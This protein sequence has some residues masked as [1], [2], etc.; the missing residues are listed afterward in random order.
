MVGDDPDRTGDRALGLF[1]IGGVRIAIDVGVL[2]EVVHVEDLKRGID[3]ADT[4]LGM[5]VIRGVLVPVIDPLRQYAPPDR[6]PAIVVVLS[7]GDM[8]TGIGVDEVGGLSR[9]PAAAV[10]SRVPGPG[11]ARISGSIHDAGSLIHVLDADALFDEEATPKVRGD[12]RKALL[13][14]R[15]ESTPYLTFD[16]G[17][18]AFAVR[19]ERVVGT[20]PRQGI[21]DRSLSCGHLL[22]TVTYFQ[23]RLPIVA[24]N[25][26]FGVG[27]PKPHDRFETVVLRFPDDRILGLAADRIVLVANGTDGSHR[28]LPDHVAAATH[29]IRASATMAGREHFI[30]DDDAILADGAI[31][32][33]AGLSVRNAATAPAPVRPADGREQALV[34]ESERY[35]LIEAGSNIGIR[36][37][38]IDGMREPPAPG[39][40]IPIERSLPGVSGLFVVDGTLVPLVRLSTHLGCAAAP[41][42]ALERVFL[43]SESGRAVG[44]LIDKV[45]GIATSEW[46]ER[47]KEAGRGAGALTP[48][49]IGLLRAYGTTEVRNIVNLRDEAAE[50][51][52][53][54]LRA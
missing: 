12:L 41:D 13:A 48:F 32:S 30:L 3:P 33:I 18:V 26:V 43:T 7:R 10:Q 45:T 5:I 34:R 44:F 35:V 19:A 25:A 49:D 31:G 20:V 15:G 52:S 29:L 36:M 46:I 47:R 54:L 51:A 16:A 42:P 6:Q 38:D 24:T 22:G 17:G 21:E 50:V 53:R 39:D 9:F 14:D 28:P 27:L 2:T 8:L 37:T 11:P 40:I 4:A 1:R 23:R